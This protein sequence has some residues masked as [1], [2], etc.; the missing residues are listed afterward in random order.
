M[1]LLFLLSLLLVGFASAAAMAEEALSPAERLQRRITVTVH[2][3]IQACAL[4]I[5][6]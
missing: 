3:I 1:R 5:D 2:S 6:N 4:G